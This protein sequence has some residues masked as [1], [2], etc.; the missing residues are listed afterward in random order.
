MAFVCSTENLPTPL[1]FIGRYW[2]RMA[3][4]DIGHPLAQAAFTRSRARLNYAN[5]D[6]A[7]AAGTYRVKSDRRPFYMGANIVPLKTTGGGAVTARVQT[8]WP[9]EMTATVAVKGTQGVRYVDLVGEVGDA[10]A[11]FEVGQGEEAMLVVANT[12]EALVYDGFKLPGTQA[13]WGLD[14]SVTLT[15]ATA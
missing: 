15:G 9:G 8:V 11:N 5:V 10:T 7:G 4:V 14:W 13:S 1:C 12:P 2:A 6:P 3:F